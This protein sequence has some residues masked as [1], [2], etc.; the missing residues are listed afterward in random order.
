MFLSGG[1]YVINEIYSRDISSVQTNEGLAVMM[2]GLLTFGLAWLVRRGHGWLKYLFLACMV[3]SLFMTRP[4]AEEVKYTTVGVI[5]T[6]LT[7]VLQIWAVILLFMIPK[8]V[9]AVSE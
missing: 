9:H 3:L 8:R 1:I 7:N 2:T 6:I 4:D 5:V